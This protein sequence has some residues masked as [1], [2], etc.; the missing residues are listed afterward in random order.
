MKNRYSELAP[1]LQNN[2]DLFINSLASG[3]NSQE[4]F[5]RAFVT[6]ELK[7]E[8]TAVVGDIIKAY[9]HEPIEGRKEYFV[10]GKVTHVVKCPD[11][12]P[13]NRGPYDD[14]PYAHYVIEVVEHSQNDD[15]I[16]G[17]TMRVPMEIFHSD[18]DER[19]SKVA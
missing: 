19:I 18:Y 13:G 1:K 11:D 10:I 8:N 6:S 3:V 16:I 12:S 15:D 4:A 7:F 5:D 17:A 14:R 2:V 9:E